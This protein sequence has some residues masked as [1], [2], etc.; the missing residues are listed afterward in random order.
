MPGFGQAAEILFFREYKEK[1]KEENVSKVT[2]ENLFFV[3][4][5][6]CR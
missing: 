2:I 5:K 4:T 6:G 3:K 1:V